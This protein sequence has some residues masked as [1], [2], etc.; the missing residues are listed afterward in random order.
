MTRTKTAL[1]VAPHRHFAYLLGFIIAVGPVSVDMYL[2]AFAQ[3]AQRFGPAVPQ[4][5]L[6]SYFAGFAVGQMAQGLLSDRFGRRGPL[7]AGL[8]L[9][10]LAS[11]GCAFAP[12]AGSFCVFRALAAFGAAASIVVPRA[13]VRD[14]A[15]GTQA[16]GLMSDVMVVMSTAPVIAPVLGSLVL[17]F[18][19]WRMIFVLAA[20]YGVA[21]LYLVVCHLPE[22]LEPGRR[23]RL[24]FV[25]ALQLFRQALSEPG[26]LVHACIGGLG[27]A[28]LFAYLAG[29][30]QVFMGQGGVTPSMFGF[31]LAVLG[32]A[33]IGF[34]RING[35]LVRRRGA[36]FALDIG[37]AVW[38]LAGAML[39]A[40]AWT[41]QTAPPAV[42]AALLVFSLGYSFIPSN[43]Q[44][45]ALSQHAAHAAT[46]TSLM[47]TLQYCAGALAGALIGVLADG[48]ARP[49]AGIIFVC[50][51]GAAA[52][53]RW[54]RRLH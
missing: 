16:A 31:L 23:T 51:L 9:Y 42:F 49:M 19:S 35:W 54:R 13:M 5:T 25:P 22:T 21:G 24:R 32:A 48:S 45:G 3:I 15:D 38:L 47:S 10:C 34:F 40:L 12:S 14:L 36:P 30:P 18:T 17:L 28:A 39:C 20:L 27:M 29:A 44:V 43:S 1:D 52:L 53:A 33:M 46:A 4:L 2:P 6:A 11:L 37:I 26:F 50:A 41:R 8:L 7:S